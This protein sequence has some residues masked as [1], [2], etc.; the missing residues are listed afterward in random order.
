MVVKLIFEKVAKEKIVFERK[1][2]WEVN[3]GKK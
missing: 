2:R 1:E 3:C